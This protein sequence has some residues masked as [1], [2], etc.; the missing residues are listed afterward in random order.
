MKLAK[1][2]IF[3]AGLG[4]T[5]WSYG[6]VASSV[7]L[8]QI[9]DKKSHIGALKPKSECVN[10]PASALRGSITSGEINIKSTYASIRDISETEKHVSFPFV[11]R[12]RGK[13]DDTLQRIVSPYGDALS[14]SNDKPIEPYV[15][16]AQGVISFSGKEGLLYVPYV[17]G[18]TLSHMTIPFDL[19]FEKAGTITVP[20]S[21]LSDEDLAFLRGGERMNNECQARTLPVF[22]T[23]APR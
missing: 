22:E 17:K 23:K 3:V 12:N 21:I 7:F 6:A 13:E 9:A 15:I 16:K 11:I 18:K 19:V 4:V 8:E 14:Y 20:L 5:S 2:A 10:I 1:V